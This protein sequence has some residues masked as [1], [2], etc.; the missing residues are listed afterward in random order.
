MDRGNFQ[1]ISKVSTIEA[2][3]AAVGTDFSSPCRNSV[4]VDGTSAPYSDKSNPVVNQ[5]LADFSKYQPG[6]KLHQWSAEGWGMGLEFQHAAES[7][8]ANLTRKG[9]MAWLNNLNKYTLDGFTRPHDY[10]PI[11]TSAPTND[12]F[13]V[14]RWQDSANTFAVQAPMTTCVPDAKWVG[15]QPTDDGS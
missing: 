2:W 6:R 15:A 13:S 10:K 11:N 14:V 5:F 8:G 7:M 12:C 9:F 1:V 3:S 4:Y